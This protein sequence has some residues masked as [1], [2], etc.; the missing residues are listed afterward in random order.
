MVGKKLDVG[1][2]LQK[3]QLLAH[4]NRAEILSITVYLKSCHVNE[5]GLTFP[6]TDRD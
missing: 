2:Q 4:S 6:E 3:Q 5:F 1:Q